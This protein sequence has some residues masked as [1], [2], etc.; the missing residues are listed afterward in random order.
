MDPFKIICVTCR[1]RLTVRD[2][3]AIGKILACPRC[4]SMVL[5]EAPKSTTAPAASVVGGAAATTPVAESVRLRDFT[6]SIAGL[7]L[8]EATPATAAEPSSLASTSAQAVADPS[9]NQFW[10]GWTIVAAGSAAA[11]LGAGLVAGVLTWKSASMPPTQSP[12]STGESIPTASAELAPLSP[13][14]AAQAV[15]ASPRQAAED[16]SERSDAKPRTVSESP[17]PAALS[18]GEDRSTPPV[19]TLGDEPREE[20]LLAS[21]TPPANSALEAIPAEDSAAKEPASAA[22]PPAE[23]QPKLRIDPLA[24]DPEGIDL[25]MLY[26]EQSPPAPTPSESESL[27]EES[28]ASHSQAP[29][30]ESAANAAEALPGMEDRE[31][32]APLPDPAALL[33]RKYPAIQ[34]EQLPLCRLLDFATQL[35]D[36]AVSV[37]PR[38]LQLA[39]VSPAAPCQVEAHDATIEQWLAEALRPLK[40]APVVEGRQIVLRRTA[41]DERRTIAYPVDDLYGD[42][43]AR[44]RL[45]AALPRL[46]SRDYW[47]RGAAAATIRLDGT[48]LRVE[49]PTSLQYEVLLI[50]EK[51]RAAAGLTPKSKYPPTLLASAWGSAQLWERLG[52]PATF[53]FPARTPLREIFRYWQ[54]ETG[55]AVLADWPALEHLGLWPRSLASLSSGGKP[56]SESLDTVLK[57]LGLGWRAVGARAIQITTLETLRDEPQLEVYR[58][59]EGSDAEAQLAAGGIP[60]DAA[61]VDQSRGVLTVFAP[62]DR[63]RALATQLATRPKDR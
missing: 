30:D 22:E 52:A 56:W 37:S 10:N 45:V 50:L 24:V 23:P 26:S 2:P 20:S 46:T 14:P 31:L 16:A 12:V 55:L 58:L 43:A 41:G 18:T 62:A 15:D 3:S 25:A 5:V 7:D 54:E 40:L 8:S 47:N 21:S 33:G 1:A 59:R 48:S 39:A 27:A 35:S 19:A 9:P 17:E 44:Q 28:A 32:S 63:Q 49:A 38:T 51:H 61:L 57:P 53:S 6:D 11:V 34:F 13:P 4:S 36:L 42:D 29:L 60:R